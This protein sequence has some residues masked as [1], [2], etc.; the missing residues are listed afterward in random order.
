MET[1]HE[2][3]RK[4]GCTHADDPSSWSKHE[5]DVRC[6]S[7]GAYS[8]RICDKCYPLP[9]ERFTPRDLRGVQ[10]CAACAAIIPAVHALVEAQVPVEHACGAIDHFLDAIDTRQYIDVFRRHASKWFVQEGDVVSI[11]D[12]ERFT[13]AIDEILVDFLTK[14]DDDGMEVM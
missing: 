3:R 6:P 9:A 10:P 7:C 14:F 8:I 1:N 2:P 5:T 13:D 4:P 12:E 11:I